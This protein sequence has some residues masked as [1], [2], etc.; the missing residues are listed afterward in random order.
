MDEMVT[1]EQV[2]DFIE[3]KETYV[4]IDVREKEE[5]SYG[6]IPTAHNVPL[7][8]FE[9]AWDLSEEAFQ[10]KYGFHKPAKDALVIFYCRTGG[11]SAQATAYVRS[12]GYKNAK[13]F[14]GSVKQWSE[15]DPNVEMY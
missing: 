4:L 1:R 11:R 13:N 10:E 5:L 14:Q 2:K 7:Q 9:D 6:M 15:I 12:K 3:G 8:E